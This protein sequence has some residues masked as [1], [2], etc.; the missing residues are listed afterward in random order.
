MQYKVAGDSLIVFLFVRVGLN[1]SVFHL[2]EKSKC[3]MLLKHSVVP[4]LNAIVL[5]QDSI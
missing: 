4:P 1:C 3:F 2:S 5:V